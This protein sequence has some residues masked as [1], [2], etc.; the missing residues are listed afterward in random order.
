MDTPNDYIN[1]WMKMQQQAFSALQSNLQS[2]YQT[3]PQDNPFAQWSKAAFAA[4]PAGADGILN[5]DIFSKALAG[6]DAMQKLYE[7]WQ[8]LLQAMQ[9]KSLDPATYSALFSGE[10]A[11]E[12]ANRVFHLDVD[13]W[14]H[15]QKQ[16]TAYLDAVQQYSRPFVDASKSQME[17]LLKGQFSADDLQPEFLAKR[18]EAMYTLFENTSGKIFGVPALGKDREKIEHMSACAKAIL[19]FVAAAIE[20]QRMMQATAAEAN[21]KLGKLMVEKT[22]AGEKFEKFDDFFNLWIDTNE[23]EFNK[24]FYSD[25][26]SAKRNAMTSAGFTV[27]KLY[28]EMLE[29]QLS[30]L[31][32]A[33]RSEMDEVYKLI[34]D[35]RKEV[36]GLKAKLQAAQNKE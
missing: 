1:G 6:N 14:T 22:A 20:Y 29:E 35:L 28:H 25:D 5:K 11:Q 21:Q 12:M 30:D 36:K 33:R 10:K 27:R 31:P 24:L 18:M 13:A 9:E 3:A 23:K 8:P 7:F 26:F 15:L 17:H 16:A 19:E 2:L 4:F 34:Y 32:I